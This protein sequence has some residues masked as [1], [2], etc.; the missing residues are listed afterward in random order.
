MLR[1]RAAIC[2][3]AAAFAASALPAFADVTWGADTTRSDVRL[4]VSQFFFGRTGGLIPFTSATVVTPDGE[5]TPLH[6]DA[7]LNA[8][9]LTTNDPQRDAVLRG[10][11]FFDVARYPEIT[12]A[13]ERVTAAGLDAFTIAGELTMRGITRP[14]VLS[15]RVAASSLAPDGSRRVRYEASGR[16]RRSDY[17]MTYVRGIVGND[18]TLAIVMELVEK[19][20]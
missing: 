1:F 13:S 8:S 10:D 17:G 15:A 5:R 9:G 4:S 11:R 7:V 20:R 2:S 14:L 16:F 19:T 18:V 3:V 6:V 12:F